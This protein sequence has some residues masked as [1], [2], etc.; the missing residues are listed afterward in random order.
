MS[1]SQLFRRRKRMMD[2]LDQDI[3]DFIERE[4]QDNIERGMSPDEARYAALRK[5]GNVT[6]VRE[7]AREV[8]SFVWLEQLWQD[9]RFGLRMLAKNPGFTAIAALTLA[10]GIGA[11]T[12]IFSVVN[13]VLVE[14]LPFAHPDS[15]V[16]V[17]DSY[18][19]GALVAMRT[20]LRSMEV[21]AYSDGQELNLSGLGDPIR[22]YGSAVSANFFSLLGAQAELGRIFLPGEDQPGKDHIVILSHTLWGQK[23]G[24]DPEVI[25]R[26]VM[27]EGESRQI[28]GVMPAG[29]QV[30]S[31]KAQFWTPL[32]LDPR[33]IGA[34]WGGG[35]MPVLGRLRTG[36]SIDQ[37]RAEVQAYLPQVRAMFPW[38]MPDAFWV[39]STVIPLRES[40]V[41]G[42]RT[43]LLVLLGAIGIV[44][45]IACANVANLLLARS[46]RRQKEMAV[47]AALGAARPR[48]CR[49]LLTE[50]VLLAMGSGS[51]G[52]IVAVG[53]L[54]LL[55]SILP[56]DTPRLATVA[57]DWHVLAFT[58]G[59]ALLTGLI[60]GVVPALHASQIDLGES[61]KA[62]WQ[63]SAAAATH[64]LRTALAVTEVA[65]AVV[66]VIGAGL[67]VKSLWEL[68]HVDPGF[69]AE[70]IMTARITPNEKFCA[71]FAQC[72]AFYN[73]LLERTRSLAGVE[74]AAVANVLPMNGRID[75]FA[76]DFEDHP[77]D[78]KDPAPVL[79]ESI[80]T[81][82][83]L[84]LM[85]IPFLRGREFT[86]ADM[87]PDAP[88]VVLIT[89]ATARKY[90]PHQ[91]PIGKHLKRVWAPDWTTVVGVVG[92]VN[93]DS[94]A[95]KLPEFADGAVYLPYGNDANAE[96]RH[97]NP[98]PTAMTLVVRTTSD[99]L[100]LAGELRKVVSSLDPDVPVSEVQTLGTVVA[101]SMATPRST[102]LLFAIFAALAL[103]L[104]AV[105]IY[106][107]ISYSVVQ[108]TPEI[109]IRLALGAQRRDVIRMV[110]RQGVRVA[111]LGVGI[112][113]AGALAL[114]RFLSTLLYG[115]QPADPLT[116]LVVSLILSGVALLASYIPARRATKVDPIVALRYE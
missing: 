62:G 69:R 12:A 17:T 73:E 84:R 31:S 75:V 34:Y 50:S 112:G 56:G 28:I 86:A 51:L 111:V 16:S 83:Y 52:V 23:F 100:S 9:V 57:M 99:R 105:G 107:V 103:G 19:Q 95:S 91:D 30:A 76:A 15:L 61:L 29:F 21:A 90:W 46:A 88:S 82:E 35:F 5:F 7:E 80:I 79:F 11:N 77:R 43:K 113:M 102:M 59:I 54:R 71:R 63:R 110:M 40:L 3:R 18:P 78:P 93:E 32:D 101:K 115:V 70:S 14:Q 72:Q 6:R 49:Q 13:G 74:D 20:H 60:F 44:L 96:D 24:G 92:D 37:A 108:R 67:M 94:L 39:S 1:W 36:V 109:G 85:R 58:A 41:G 38:R 89:A 97:G 2:D 8:W 26:W 48:I 106:G 81:P 116:F 87:G 22:L 104:G 27:L 10:L 4:T 55:K 42:V 33:A 53:G 47:R 66:L 114:T 68:S 98:H 64:R 25:G 45:L 65:L